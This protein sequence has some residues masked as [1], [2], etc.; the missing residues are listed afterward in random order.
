MAVGTFSD[1]FMSFSCFQAV[2]EPVSWLQ[3]LTDGFVA[4]VF[5]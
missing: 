2:S 1:G 5:F 3:A 4:F